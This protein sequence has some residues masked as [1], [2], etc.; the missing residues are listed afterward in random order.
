[1]SQ[2][3]TPSTRSG[4]S[5]FGKLLTRLRTPTS[6]SPSLIK[7]QSSRSSFHC[8]DGGIKTANS[9]S[10]LS[11]DLE[12]DSN[13]EIPMPVFESSPFKSWN[14]NKSPYE[15]PLPQTSQVSLASTLNSL[16]GQNEDDEEI[17]KP[18]FSELNSRSTSSLSFN[19][20]TS[21]KHSPEIEKKT[22]FKEPGSINK[23]LTRGW[24]KSKELITRSRT[25]SNAASVASEPEKE[26]DDATHKV[27]ALNAPPQ[28]NSTD[29]ILPLE[30]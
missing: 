27:S 23:S 11:L 19:S 16:S 4:Q 28:V 2:P 14:S 29:L 10:S 25:T 1:M 18:P 8:Y 15:L 24:A 6:N 13:D 3:S 26:D 12:M 17:I 21:S 20:S 7:R 30:K 5:T 9:Q 22:A